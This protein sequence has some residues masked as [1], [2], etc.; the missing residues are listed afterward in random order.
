MRAGRFLIAIVIGMSTLFIVAEGIEFVAVQM[1]A[2]RW[3]TE[4]HEYF[5]IRNRPGMLVLKFGYQLAA[6][7]LAGYVGALVAGHPFER[8][9]GLTTGMVQS[10][11]F[12]VALLTPELRHNAPDWVWLALM[13]LTIF[14]FLT[15]A[16]VRA[17][18]S[19]QG[20][21]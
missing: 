1:A 20:R 13:P 15:G 4:P 6:T 11:M 21:R 19:I 14:G 7:I 2:P 16:R 10:G 18:S 17:M 12:V 9:V 5:A 3:T 8:T